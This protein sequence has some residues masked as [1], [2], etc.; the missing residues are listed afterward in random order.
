M[1]GIT[2]AA[3]ASRD[4]LS[5]R[6]AI[7][8]L[9]KAFPPEEV[10]A[11]IDA[12]G[13]REQRSRAL[14]ARTMVYFTLALWLFGGAGYDAVLARLTAGMRWA[15]VATG[16]RSAPSTGSITK[17]RK[18][19]GPDVMR[20]LFLGRA[21]ADRAE[22]ARWRGMRVCT[23]DAGVVDIPDTAANL[24]AFDHSKVRVSVLAGHDTGSLLDVAVGSPREELGARVLDTIS[25]GT[26]VVAHRSA[27]EQDLWRAAANR[28][29]DL[30][31]RARAPIT[32]PRLHV[33]PD[34]SFLSR[35][36][37]D[38]DPVTDSLA[39]RVLQSPD[40]VLVTTLLDPDQAP[41]AELAALH[42]TRWRFE[43]LFESLEAGPVALRSQDPHGVAQELW[44]MLCV[45]QAVHPW[46]RKEAA[47]R[48]VSAGS[49]GFGMPPRR[50]THQ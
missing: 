49:G 39:V 20:R 44:A 27:G 38:G 41:A 45:Y 31:W 21:A 12:A 35:M 11:A 18:R 19:L 15:G 14:P 13:A 29:A 40:A 37:A 2:R 23:L 8:M 17:A 26:L 36:L 46:R 34:G 25:P 42:R 3:K 6:V 22:A 24:A 47:M 5:D 32:L 7:G 33:L 30:L 43:A 50:G 4:R 9:L 16:T 10:D 1:G 48:G 28:G